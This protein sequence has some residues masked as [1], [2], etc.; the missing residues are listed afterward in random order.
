MED[1]ASKIDVSGLSLAERLAH[2]NWKVRLEA[3]E[4]LEVLFK[5]AEDGDKCFNEYS[6]HAYFIITLMCSRFYLEERIVG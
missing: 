1:S 3:Y 5:Q 6:T 2:K 4:N